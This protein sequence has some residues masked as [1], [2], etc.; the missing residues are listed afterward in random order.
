ML[1]QSRELGGAEDQHHP[2][3]GWRAGGMILSSTH[4]E[5][6]ES[7]AAQVQ[8]LNGNADAGRVAGA[9]QEASEFEQQQGLLRIAWQ[10]WRSLCTEQI[11]WLSQ[12]E[13]RA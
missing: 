2:A 6:A 3:A 12:E 7:S 10:H 11:G 13:R 8:G 5:A 9:V 1:S 4:A